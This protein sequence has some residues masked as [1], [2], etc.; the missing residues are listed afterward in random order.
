ME[1]ERISEKL[2]LI[3]KIVSDENELFYTQYD[4]FR[5]FCKS[6]DSRKK[7]TD[8]FIEKLT[9]IDRVKNY[10]DSIM[11]A[12]QKLSLHGD[13]MSPYEIIYYVKM[14]Q[15]NSAN[16]KKLLGSLQT[17][18]TILLQIINE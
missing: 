3:V 13:E 4:T 10:K 14:F 5:S 8:I 2:N 12:V 16:I 9:D 1:V 7:L 6:V 18:Q 11:E 15:D 17:S